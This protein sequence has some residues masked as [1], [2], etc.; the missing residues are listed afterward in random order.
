M[1][2][3]PGVA[4]RAVHVGDVNLVWARQD[5]LGN[6]VG[7]RDDEVIVGD[8]ELLDSNRHEG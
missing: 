5:A 8:V 4:Y 1:R 3:V 2:E 7:T 6:A